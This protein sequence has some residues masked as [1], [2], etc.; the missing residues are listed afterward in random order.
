MADDAYLAAVTML[1][2]REL[3]EFQIRQRLRRKGFPDEAVDE[4]LYNEQRN[5]VVFIKY[6][7]T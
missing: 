1:A 7:D 3:S 6:L 4:L 2:R 5:E